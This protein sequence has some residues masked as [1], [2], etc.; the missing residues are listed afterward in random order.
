MKSLVKG[1]ALISSGVAL[2][3]IISLLAQPVLTRLF[4]P[5]QFGVYS[6]YL[7]L[8]ALLIPVVS[9]SF[10]Y[11]IFYAT[12]KGGKR[13]VIQLSK[14]FLYIYF[15]FSTALL[16]FSFFLQWYSDNLVLFAASLLNAVLMSYILLNQ[17]IFV[18]EGKLK[19]RGILHVGMIIS[20]ALG[21]IISHYFVFDDKSMIFGHLL[22]LFAFTIIIWI[23]FDERRLPKYT[24]LRNINSDYWS[25]SKYKTFTG[26][27][28]ALSVSLPIFAISFYHGQSSVG[29]YGLAYTVAFAPALLIGTAVYE[30]SLRE[31]K[32]RR[33]K[34]LRIPFIKLSL[35]FALFVLL[36][37]IVCGF[38]LMYGSYIFSFIFGVDWQKSSEYAAY[39]VLWVFGSLG[40][41]PFNAL[42]TVYNLEKHNSFIEVIAILIRVLVLGAAGV[43]FTSPLALVL[44]FSVAN[45]FINIARIYILKYY[46]PGVVN[47]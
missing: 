8:T 10:P 45:I 7:T 2:G 24:Q 39:M 11:L 4:T 40:S 18:D 1:V 30:V 26:L 43:I 42:A 27:L 38:L 47:A 35:F 5:A 17:L 6:L 13:E 19:T 3:H 12:D 20:I 31:L 34:K 9:L 36:G 33:L 21:K 32:S 22:L 41:R 37:L 28:S 29:L 15:I 44:W 14:L 23:L 16:L 25:F 46:F